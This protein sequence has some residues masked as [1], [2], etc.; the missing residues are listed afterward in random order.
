MA[1]APTPPYDAQLLTRCEVCALCQYLPRGQRHG[2]DQC[3]LCH[4]EIGRFQREIRFVHSDEVGEGAD[5]P[6]AR[7]P[8]DLVSDLKTRDRRSHAINNAN[9]IMA[10]NEGCTIDKHRLAFA[11]RKLVSSG[12]ALA[13]WIL[14]SIPSSASLGNGSAPVWQACFFLY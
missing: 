9:P 11:G 5:S 12:F 10:K 4:R 14:A 13:K 7:A 6:I 8:V 1:M 3:G 2:R